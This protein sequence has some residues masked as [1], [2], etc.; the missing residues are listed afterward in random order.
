MGDFWLI[1]P[2]AYVC[3]LTCFKPANNRKP[4]IQS[5]RKCLG[6]VLTLHHILMIAVGIYLSHRLHLYCVT[7]RAQSREDPLSLSRHSV[8]I[9][10]RGF[11]V[12]AFWT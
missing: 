3:T 10:A 7:N 6:F 12:I 2:S 5:K 9:L 11:S 8:F 1:S 4:R